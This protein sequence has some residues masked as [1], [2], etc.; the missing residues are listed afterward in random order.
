MSPRGVTEYCSLQRLEKPLMTSALPPRRRMR[1]MTFLRRPPIWGRKALKSSTRAIKTWSSIASDS[2]S[3]SRMTGPKLSTMSSL[4]WAFVSLLI[5][6]TE[7]T[8]ER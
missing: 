3:T 1:L 5:F 8:E 2:I 6:R 7:L 4:L